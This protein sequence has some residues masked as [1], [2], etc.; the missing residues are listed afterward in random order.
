MKL[1]GENRSTQ[2]KTCPSA[3]LSTTNVAWTDLGSN[4]GLRGGPPATDLKVV[5]V[6]PF[7]KISVTTVNVFSVYW[8]PIVC[9]SLLILLKVVRFK[10]ETH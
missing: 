2:G 6:I 7:I 4:P 1:T 5:F 10:A 8:V 3:T 9:I